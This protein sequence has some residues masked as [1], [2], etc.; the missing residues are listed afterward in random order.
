MLGR[1]SNDPLFLQAKE[2]PRSVLERFAGRSEFANQGQRVVEGQ[3]LMQAASDIFLGWLR[4]P[5]G[6]EDLKLRDLYVRQLWDS[7]ITADIAAMGP[8]DMAVYA[9][10]CAW[11]LA[12]AHARSGDSIAIASYLGSSDVFDR[13]IATFAEA[14]ADQNERDH[15][16]LLHAIA[17]G[18]VQADPEL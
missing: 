11:T 4:Q 18:R 16:A 14:Y 9:R 6:L 17:I 3:R 7:K 2:A 5:P 15:A 8:S 10:L 12:R 1:D 13:A